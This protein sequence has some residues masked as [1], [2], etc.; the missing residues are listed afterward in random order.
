MDDEEYTEQV[1]SPCAPGD[2]VVL[3]TDGIMEAPHPDT[4]EEYGLDRFMSCVAK[5]LLMA[6]RQF[7]VPCSGS[8]KLFAGPA[9][10]DHVGGSGV[11]SVKLL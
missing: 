1:V 9:R 8:R 2:I 5:M 7:K 10:D 4:G 6:Q 11:Q 3:A